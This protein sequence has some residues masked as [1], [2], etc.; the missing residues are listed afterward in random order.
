[1]CLRVSEYVCVRACGYG[2]VRVIIKVYKYIVYVYVHMDLVV[3]S[4][5]R[6][7]GCWCS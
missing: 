5:G 4:Y 7:H 2:G 3:H 1:M 6:V